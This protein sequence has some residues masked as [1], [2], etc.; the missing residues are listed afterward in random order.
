[1]DVS[2]EGYSR[3]FWRHVDSPLSMSQRGEKG[4]KKAPT[5]RTK[6]GTSWMPSGIRLDITTRP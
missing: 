3:F 2:D 5:Q 4:R 1:M 6:A